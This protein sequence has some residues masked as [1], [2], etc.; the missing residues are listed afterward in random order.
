[1]PVIAHYSLIKDGVLAID[2]RAIYRHE[3]KEAGAAAFASALYKHME[4]SYLKFFKM[5]NLSKLGFLA[6][7]ALTKAVPD[8]AETP[9]DKTGL[10]LMNTH[11]SLDTDER[12]YETVANDEN[13]FPSPALF[14]YTLPN[15]VIGE[16]CIRHK[17]TGEHAFLLSEQPDA[18]LLCNYVRN[19]FDENA[20][21]AA[22]VGWVEYYG[23]KRHA[24]LMWV[25]RLPGQTG[26]RDFTPEAIQQLW[27]IHS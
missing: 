6:A 21:D 17:I 7:E 23:A 9:K 27:T 14:V 4:L 13:N 26:A 16:I 3:D 24:L 19:V 22:I 8:F 12:Y 25:N 2:G 1:M 18:T 11:S 20:V 10:F 5:D 15:I